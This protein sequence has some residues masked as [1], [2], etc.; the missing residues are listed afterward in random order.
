MKKFKFLF[1][2]ALVAFG[3]TA[4]VCGSC[5]DDEDAAVPSDNKGQGTIS[6][7]RGTAIDLG[8]SVKWASVNVGAERP[9]D[10][11]GYFA[12]GETKEKDDYTW[13]KYLHYNNGYVN[14][15]DDIGGTDYDVAH[16]QWGGRWRMPTITEFEE[17][18]DNCT[19]TWTVRDG[20]NGYEVTGPN[21]N[22]IFLPAAGFRLGSSLDRAG[23]CGV[24]W[25]SSL[26]TSSSYGARYLYFYSGE[27]TTGC[28]YDYE[29]G[30]SVRPVCP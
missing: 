2:L 30:Q 13:E 15:G 4:G 1:T 20:V 24:Y 21:G 9:E 17:L 3:L 16:V 26:D 5:G 25:S 14:I 11:G 27:Y 7:K 22:S 10:Y 12:W 6:Y 19:W 29:N 23:T 18:I 28:N 8:L